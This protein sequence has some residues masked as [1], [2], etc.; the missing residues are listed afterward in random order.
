MTKIK[1]CHLKVKMIFQMLDN[2]HETQISLILRDTFYTIATTHA[3]NVW[4]NNKNHPA[5]E[6][7]ITSHI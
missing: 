2:S 6:S 4:T 5:W 7:R 1:F 3:M